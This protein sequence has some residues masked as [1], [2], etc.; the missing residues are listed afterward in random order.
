MVQKP[1]SV[2]YKVILGYLLLLVMAAFSVWLVYTEIS[3]IARP[4][5]NSEENQK[6]IRISNTITNLYAS[7][8]LARTSVL[9][10]ADKDFNKYSALI[11]SI[12]HEIN[13][14]KQ[15]VEEG[16]MAKFDSI[17]MLLQRKRK[18][19]VE[20]I[21]YR[22]KHKD[23]NSF[24]RAIEGVYSTKDSI[25]D[26]TK[27][28]RLTKRHQWRSTIEAL[29]TE[30]QRDSLSKIISIDSFAM[31]YDKV[32]V[33]LSKKD[34]KAKHILFRQELRLQDENNIISDQLR[35]ILTSVENEFLQN[36][37][38]TFKQSQS[39]MRKTIENIA[40]IG[41][42]ALFIL[43]IFAWIIIRDLTIN[44]NYRKQ[45]E[46]LNHE[47]EELLRT[48]SMLMAT[49]THDL[50]T[51]LGSI[52]GFHDLLKDSETTPK[53]KQYLSNIKESANYILKLVNDLLD[54][55]RLENNRISIEKTGFNFRNLIENTCKTLEPMASNKGIELN[56]DISD[57]LN[58][59]YIS[60]PYRIKQVLTNLVSNAIKFTPEGSV[61]VTA[62][63][64]GNNI[65]ISVIDTGIGIARKKHGDVFKEFTQAHSGIEK[66]FGGTGLGLTISQKILELLDGEILLESEEGQGSIF[67]VIIPCI[68]S[69]NNFNREAIADIKPIESYPAIKNKKILIVDDDNMQLTLMKELL[70]NYP[71]V[72]RTEIN[73]LSVIS[74]LE[75]E[76]F[77]LMLTD[78]QMPSLDG[79]ELIKSIRGNEHNSIASLPVI[80]LSGKR[81]LT[82]KDFTDAGFT[83]H[84]PKPIQL[85]K[86][87]NLISYIFS[88]QQTTHKQPTIPTAEKFINVETNT[89]YNLRSLSQFTNN[90][91]TSLRTIVNTFIDSAIDNCESLKDAAFEANE[92]RLAEIAHKMIPMLKQM[93]VFSIVELLLPLEDRVIDMEPSELTAYVNRLCSKLETLCL[94][95]AKEVN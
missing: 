16:Q 46:I 93:E 43:I 75:E 91:P 95:L 4:G 88:S 89:L 69:S 9:T 71:V 65:Y 51:P 34:Y 80:A 35:A 14:I 44:Q 62:K 57:E 5:Q 50:Q 26:N 7:E 20:I 1:K 36:S 83:G 22:T 84:H 73:A 15:T 13:D 8:A 40:W 19:I 82:D 11:D 76:N 52:I 21:I 12:N 81:D 2:T 61:E 42:L 25:I 67:T 87:L 64:E 24:S 72:L 47:N 66:K 63:I 29:L 39:G 53:Q 6:I 30:E 28:V 68:P 45:L 92:Q 74:L 10:L 18:S 37:Y 17:Q 85:E 3:K 33:D 48:K 59:N 54:F 41:A 23:F 94:E 31:A 56:W 86:L 38:A 70:A 58:G 27:P 55:S 49:V 32:L 77:D 90:D 79:F 78:I 60:D